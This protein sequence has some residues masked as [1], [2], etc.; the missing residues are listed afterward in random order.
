MQPLYSAPIYLY[1]IIFQNDPG[2]L[3]LFSNILTLAM[4]YLLN[5]TNLIGHLNI[6]IPN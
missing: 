3:L 4:I 1:Y 5:P 6:Q 2:A